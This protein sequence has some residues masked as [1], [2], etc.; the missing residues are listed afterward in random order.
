M[1]HWS[2][3]SVTGTLCLSIFG[4]FCNASQQFTCVKTG[5]RQNL[6]MFKANCNMVWSCRT[7]TATPSLNTS[8]CHKDRREVLVLWTR[9]PKEKQ[10]A[11]TERPGSCSDV[12]EPCE[13][14]SK[15]ILMHLLPCSF[16]TTT[17]ADPLLIF[18]WKSLLWFW[19]LKVSM[20]CSN[21]SL[22]TRNQL[23]PNAII[24]ASMHIEANRGCV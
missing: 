12:C 14:T 8:F 16:Y 19:S 21:A 10:Q 23:L 2:P 4:P 24:S 3:N 6:P 11:G 5:C 7:S 20:L 9:K 17:Q 1:Q 22:S 18:C 15:N 13:R